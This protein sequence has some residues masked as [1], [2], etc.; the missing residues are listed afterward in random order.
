MGGKV[1]DFSAAFACS[2]CHE[3]IDQRMIKDNERWYYM[4]R[5]LFRTIDFWFEEGLITAAGMRKTR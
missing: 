5:A 4:A 2:S 3:A 1:P